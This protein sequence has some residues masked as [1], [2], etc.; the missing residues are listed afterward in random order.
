MVY[1]GN[2]WPAPR[3]GRK[4]LLDGGK[5]AII[6][7]GKRKKLISMVSGKPLMPRGRELT[8]NRKG[9]SFEKKK[10]RKFQYLINGTLGRASPLGRVYLGERKVSL[11]YLE[12]RHSIV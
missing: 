3:K 1:G 7:K 8:G 12:G 4:L 6:L 2:G 5:K 10:R 9:R 11:R